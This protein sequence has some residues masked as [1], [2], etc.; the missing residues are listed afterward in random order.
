MASRKKKAAYTKKQVYDSV[1][2]IKE[3]GESASESTEEIMNALTAGKKLSRQMMK[4]FK[5]IKKARQEELV[6]LSDQIEK[7][8]KLKERT[9]FLTSVEEDNLKL[10]KEKIKVVK[11]DLTLTERAIEHQENLRSGFERL[12]IS[13]AALTVS[14]G[15]LS[16]AVDIVS[17]AF[18]TLTS[19]YDNWFRLQQT[20]QSSMAGLQ[21]NTG[22]TADQMD[23]ARTIIES[24]RNE[25]GR[26]TSEVDGIAVTS[27]QFGQLANAVRDLSILNEDTFRGLVT[28]QRGFGLAADQANVV[29]RAVTTG[30]IDAQAE[31]DRF[32]ADMLTF[33]DQIGAPAGVIM[34]DYAQAASNVAEFGRRG[35]DT[36]RRAAMM[37]NRFGFETQKIFEM[38]KKFDTFSAAA[39][40]VNTLNAMFG[41]TLSS[42]EM[43]ITQDPTER[44]E[45]VREAIMNTGRAWDDMNRFQRMQIADTLGVDVE[46]AA[47]MFR[48][49]MSFEDLDR[50][51]AEAAEEQRRQERLQLSNQEMMNNLLR[52]TDEFIDSIGRTWQEIKNIFSEALGPIFQVIRDITGEV[53]ADIRD[54]ADYLANSAEGQ[55]EVAAFAEDLRDF[56]REA[57]DWAKELDWNEIGDGAMSFMRTMRD[58]S[59]WVYDSLR[60]MVEFG[61]AVYAVMDADWEKLGEITLDR[62]DRGDGLFGEGMQFSGVG[63]PN[64]DLSE[65]RRQTGTAR[66]ELEA[67][68]QLDSARQTAALARYLSN[69]PIMAQNPAT[70][71]LFRGPDAQQNLQRLVIEANL[72]MDGRQVGRQIIETTTREAAANRAT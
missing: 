10:M 43:M 63:M 39:D 56:L 54:W 72:H 50:Q 65:V 8:E 61:R 71:A 40:N 62:L 66:A 21:M 24:F 64:V 67:G 35:E 26:M 48:D 44:L 19:L 42:Y 49:N 9:G 22:L 16:E 36:F 30:A 25:M 23:Y 47:R 17:A 32:G 1:G 51:R 13:T 60:G 6:S 45:M 37:A 46:Q 7:T 3:L 57:V 31:M 41:T 20:W 58:I 68:R 53:S 70:Q 29:F 14:Y 12:N 15:L 4:H 69:N 2:L 5:S 52:R 18:R 33:A 38:V 28:L 27:E 34:R 55:A 59:H 11:K